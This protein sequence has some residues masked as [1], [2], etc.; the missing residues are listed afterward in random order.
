MLDTQITRVQNSV[1]LCVLERLWLYSAWC[2]LFA[3]VLSVDSAEKSQR[4][5]IIID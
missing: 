5:K 3:H 2:M 4:P 1:V